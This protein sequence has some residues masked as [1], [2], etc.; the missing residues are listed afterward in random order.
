MRRPALLRA[1]SLAVL[2]AFL[3]TFAHSQSNSGTVTGTITDPTGAVVPGA[4]VEIVNH[5]SGY[6]R[7]A[8]TD[9]SGQFRFYNIPFN[10]YRVTATMTGFGA[11]TKSADVSTVVPVV[12]PIKF[13][14]AEASTTVTVE[15]GSDLIENDSTFHTDVDRSTIDRMPLESQSSSLSSIVTLSSPGVTADSNGLFHGLGDHA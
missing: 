7:T 10:P 14:L 13:G 4:T 1:F 8:K 5:V 3:T 15:G 11:V 2:F 12:L 6:K 9:A